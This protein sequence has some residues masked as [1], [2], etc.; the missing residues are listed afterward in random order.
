MKTQETQET[1]RGR[2]RRAAAPLCTCGTRR[3]TGRVRR[4]TRTRS[5]TKTSTFNVFAK[6]S[7]RR[8]RGRRSLAF[9]LRRGARAAPSEITEGS[10]RESPVRSRGS[11]RARRAMVYVCVLY[12]V[13]RRESA[14]GRAARRRETSAL[15]RGSRAKES[16]R[17][18][19]DSRRFRTAVRR[20]GRACFITRRRTRG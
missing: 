19:L 10:D 9:R 13:S 6:T 1:R 18:F 14:R 15:R 20:R 5:S 11:G 4:R 16:T 2:K 12:C 8:A 17:R 3:T 7:P